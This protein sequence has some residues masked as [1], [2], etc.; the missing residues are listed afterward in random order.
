MIYVGD[1]VKYNKITGIVHSL[2]YSQ[3]A[4]YANIEGILNTVSVADLKLIKKCKYMRTKNAC[5][6]KFYEKTGRR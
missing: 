2:M 3:G 5:G 1:K 6:Y 4:L